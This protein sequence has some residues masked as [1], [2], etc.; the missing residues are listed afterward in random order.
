MP[1][2]IIDCSQNV[3]NLASPESIMQNVYDTAD[4]TGLF[5]KG[6]IKV[7]VN[8]FSH[9]NIGEAESFIHV[10]GNIMEGRTNEQK[11]ELSRAIVQKLKVLL[12]GVPIVSMNL[13]DFEKASYANRQ[14]E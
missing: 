2:F 7:R 12:P 10:F 11:L 1:H 6:D 13:R 9:Y 14:M 3:L 5:A 8:P 4:A